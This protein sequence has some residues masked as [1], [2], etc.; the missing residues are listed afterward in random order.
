MGINAFSLTNKIR[1]IREKND[2]MDPDY[3]IPAFSV[4]FRHE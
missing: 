1:S 4:L 3:I 2:L